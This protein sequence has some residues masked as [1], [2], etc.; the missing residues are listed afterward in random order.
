MRSIAYFPEEIATMSAIRTSLGDIK[1]QSRRNA[2]NSPKSY[3]LN[4]KE[5]RQLCGTGLVQQTAQIVVRFAH[6]I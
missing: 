4:N 3:F 6:T 5:H 2:P 1:Q